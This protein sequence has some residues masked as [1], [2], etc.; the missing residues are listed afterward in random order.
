MIPGFVG[1]EFWGDGEKTQAEFD[2]QFSRK[3]APLERKQVFKEVH[4]EYKRLFPDR[5]V[6]TTES[7]KVTSEKKKEDKHSN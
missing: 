3:I 7:K 5:K 1:V 6:K 4:K 2:K